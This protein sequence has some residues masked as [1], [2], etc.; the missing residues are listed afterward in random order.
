MLKSLPESIFTRYG[1]HISHLNKKSSPH[2]FKDH[3]QYAAISDVLHRKESHHL[4]LLSDAADK[5]RTVFLEGLVQQFAHDIIYFN[6]NLFLLADEQPEKVAQGFQQLLA[7]REAGKRLFFAINDLAWLTDQN[8]YLARILRSLITD[9]GWSFIILVTK[10]TFQTFMQ[11]HD[12]PAGFTKL[13]MVEP[14]EQ[15]ALALLRL[16]RTELEEYHHVVIPDEIL[17]Y[18]YELARRY[19]SF[20][21]ALDKAFLLLDSSAARAIHNEQHEG[22]NAMKPPVTTA[23]VTQVLATWT[24]ITA[25]Q[26]QSHKFRPTEF[27]QGMHQHLFGQETAIGVIT[28]ALQQAYLPLGEKTGPFASF[29]FVGATHVGKKT[30]ALSVA[31]LLFKQPQAFFYANF[32]SENVLNNLTDLKVRDNRD[33]RYQLLT[34]IIQR[35]PYAVI[36]LDNI[37]NATSRVL[38]TLEEIL[39]SGHLLDHSGNA[40]DFRQAIIILATNVGAEKIQKSLPVRQ[41]DEEALVG[42]LMHLVLAEPT[43]V[44]IST[45]ASPTLPQ[46]LC[47]EL[48]PSLGTYF[49]TALLHY[50]TLTPFAPLNRTAIERIIRGKLKTLTQRLNDYYDV[51][52]SYA[53]EVIRYL[54]QE[55]NDSKQLQSIDKVLEQCVHTLVA[56]TLLTPTP[57]GSVSRQ[58]FLQLNDTGQLLRCD[59]VSRKTMAAV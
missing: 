38:L 56:Q 41:E 42:D 26:L 25:S 9:D 51:E 21:R 44:D 14:N 50:L 36:F 13:E 11:Q 30:A 52:L 55:V 37:Q 39:A 1:R 58:L 45:T 3:P 32:N 7:A 22:I 34:T 35:T 27:L 29:L 53:S 47:E 54:I 43:V 40:F 49:S 2:P 33:S 16:F 8:D 28:H 17:L 18:S 23:C 48:L 57:N 24:G 31:E 20:S 19:L 10:Q 59:W 6:R 12:L 15:Q 5:I 46:A 4:I